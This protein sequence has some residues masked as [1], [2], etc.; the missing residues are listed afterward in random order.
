MST[1]FAIGRFV[2]LAGLVISHFFFFAIPA[3]KEYT[4]KSVA[5][6]V[7]EE[8]AKYLPPPTITLCPYKYWFSGWKNA[9]VATP[10]FLGSYGEHCEDAETK[11]DILQCIENK[12]FNLTDTLP[13]RAFRGIMVDDISSS[14]FW[15][16]DFT[17]AVDGRCFTLNY[18]EPMGADILKDGFLFDLNPDLA[19]LIYIHRPDFFLVSY[20]PLTMPTLLYDYDLTMSGPNI[21]QMLFLQ[22][23]REE[24]LNRAGHVCNEDKDYNF[25]T[26][27]R[28]TLSKKIGCK[29]PWDTDTTGP[30]LLLYLFFTL[31]GQ[32]A[33]NKFHLGLEVCSTIDQFKRFDEEYYKLAAN[34]KVDIE[35]T[36]CL[37]PC[38]FTRYEV[39]F[40][41]KSPLGHFGLTVMFGS[42]TTT[43]RK[44]YYIYPV[45]SFIS[46]IGGSLGL[47][48]GFSFFM[49]WD[50]MKD[51]TI[52]GRNISV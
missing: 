45:L 28:N 49:V 30:L 24:K 14:D 41:R 29:L 31:Y 22:V 2:F 1:I 7:F 34:L 20:I 11:E 39:E 50:I 21:H 48:V 18:T 46:D 4:A 10:N 5:V 47:F 36:G 52:I 37:F 42:L 33:I 17:A 13:A 23:Y 32:D 3:Y 43:V 51:V 27:I 38:T 19:Y 40:T 9:T 25:K 35:S 16:T 15:I 6:E 44:E 8:D 12:T 26:C